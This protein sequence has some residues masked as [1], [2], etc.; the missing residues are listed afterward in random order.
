MGIANSKFNPRLKYRKSVL[1]EDQTWSQTLPDHIFEEIML[2][3]GLE[4]LENL[5]TCRQVCKEWNQRIMKKLRAIRDHPNEKWG[6]ILRNRIEKCW[7]PG[8]YP[9]DRI[10][11]HAKTL[12]I[13]IQNYISNYHNVYLINFDFIGKGLH[14]W[15]RVRDSDFEDPEA[16][17][18]CWSTTDKICLK[19]CSP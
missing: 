10:I 12:G 14:F 3:I 16:G 5:D 7:G 2:M 11:M 9:S 13:E 1:T 15:T 6:T 4:S 8:N 18:F 19:L 17:L